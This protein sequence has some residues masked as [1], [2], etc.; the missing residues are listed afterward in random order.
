MVSE[1]PG[2]NA[3]DGIR[4][5]APG[6]PAV[7]RHRDIKYLERGLQVELDLPE[8]DNVER[9]ACDCRDPTQAPLVDGQQDVGHCEANGTDLH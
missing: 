3:F 6:E 2:T 7:D 8:D 9:R 5:S 1:R 4:G